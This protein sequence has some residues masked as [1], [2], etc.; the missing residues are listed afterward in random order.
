M[1]KAQEE[2]SSLVQRSGLKRSELSEKLKFSEASI[3]RVCSGEQHPRPQVLEVLRQLVAKVSGKKTLV[4][5]GA[6]A[7]DFRDDKSDKGREMDSGSRGLVLQT[8]ALKSTVENC[9]SELREENKTERAALKILV[10][11]AVES[12]KT[13][14]EKGGISSPENSIIVRTEASSPTGMMGHDTSALLRNYYRACVH[15]TAVYEP[16]PKEVKPSLVFVCFHSE[17]GGSEVVLETDV[18]QRKKY[19]FLS[20]LGAVVEDTCADPAWSRVGTM[21]HRT[22]TPLGLADNSEDGNEEEA[23]WVRRQVWRHQAPRP[24]KPVDSNFR[25]ND[26]VSHVPLTRHTADTVWRIMKERGIRSEEECIAF[27]ASE[28]LARQE[29]DDKL[30]EDQEES[31]VDNAS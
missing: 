10:S 5:I 9:V 19:D 28:E 6:H 29:E 21:E 22:P 17:D 24:V 18:Y 3:S 20:K 4:Y 31:Q 23:P 11:N 30:K 2:F 8:D 14:W 1:T 27:L 25:D 7:T 15:N 16:Q 13:I 26:V 12:I